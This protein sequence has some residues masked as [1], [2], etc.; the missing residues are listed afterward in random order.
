[1]HA[2]VCVYVHVY[3]C[4]HTCACMCARVHACT[5]AQPWRGGGGDAPA[6]PAE[7]LASAP[8]RPRAARRS[9]RKLL[10][11][12]ELGGYASAVLHP[13]IKVL[14]GPHDEVRREALDTICV[15]AVLMGTDFTLFVPIIRKVGCHA[16][17]CAAAAAVQL[18][19]GGL[20]VAKT[21]SSAF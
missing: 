11:R 5:R 10:P 16:A 20:M 7:D 19:R 8:T 4:I 1:M 14:D 12:M 21:G 3:A 17:A 9:M 18:M 2:C 13:L 6:K 15:C